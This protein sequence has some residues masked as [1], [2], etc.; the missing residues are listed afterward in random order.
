MAQITDSTNP[1]YINFLADVV[2]L[3]Q[4][5]KYPSNLQPVSLAQN[6]HFF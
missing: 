5:G 2:H 6:V 3:V 1:L 4:I